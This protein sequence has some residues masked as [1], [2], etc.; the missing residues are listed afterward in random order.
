MTALTEDALRSSRELENQLLEEEKAFAEAVSRSIEAQTG[1]NTGEQAGSPGGDRGNSEESDSTGCFGKR[2]GKGKKHRDSF[3]RAKRR[4]K[5][6]IRILLGI[7]LLLLLLVGTFFWLR[8]MGENNLKK[9]IV[10]TPVEVVVPEE[11]AEEVEEE[12]NE[13]LVVYNGERYWYNED[14]ITVLCIGVDREEFS[15]PDDMVIGGNG[16]ADADVLVIFDKKNGKISFLNISRDCMVD[17]DRYN[18]QGQ[19]LDTV[20]EQLC[21]SFA[22]GNGQ[23]TS[24]E[25]TALSVSRLLY[26]IPINAYVAIDFNSIGTLND[27]VGGVSVPVTEDIAHLFPGTTV[28]ALVNL[29]GSEAVTYVRTRDTELLDSNNTRMARQKQYILAFLRKAL[30]QIKED[31]TK[32][33][34]LFNSVSDNMV[35]SIKL[36][37]VTYFG[38]FFAQHGFKEENLTSLQGEVVLG[39]DDFA[40]FIPDEKALF[41]TVLNLFYEK[42]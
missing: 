38:T 39:E 27:A 11:V 36:S 37:E 7:V 32:A 28:G 17:L 35:T 22:F 15:S 14:V 16:Q 42:E 34:A 21:L 3:T 24:C 41:E 4:K 29:V 25:N 10:E 31:P 2:P 40:Q 23:Q 13:N 20:K 1:E 33:L 19:Y 26:G 12:D 18:I 6:L 5:I 8:Y 30:E 9:N